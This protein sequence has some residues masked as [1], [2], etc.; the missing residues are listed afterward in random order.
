LEGNVR[1]IGRKIEKLSIRDKRSGT[2]VN[3]ITASFG[4][5]EFCIGDTI[6]TF[7]TR[8]DEPLYQAKRLG[9]NRVLPL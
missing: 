6:T 1:K 2:A 5:S 8:A 3:N 9:R 7:I 4:V